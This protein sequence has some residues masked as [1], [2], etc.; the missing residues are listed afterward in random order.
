VRIT[1]EDCG[2]GYH[3]IVFTKQNRLSV[4][5]V[6]LTGHDLDDLL[7]VL[8]QRKAATRRCAA[9]NGEHTCG[10][11]PGHDDLRVHGHPSLVYPH[12]CRACPET[13][14]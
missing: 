10:S 14:T 4:T 12:E 11:W 7:A 3:D 13:W 2:A 9:E 1:I 6:S 8:E 5:T